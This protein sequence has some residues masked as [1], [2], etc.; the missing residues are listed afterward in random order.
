MHTKCTGVTFSSVSTVVHC[1][2]TWKMAGCAI[3]CIEVFFVDVL[4]AV[5]CV[6]WH[7]F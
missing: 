7:G 4:I 6:M 2:M 5:Y 1:L 3:K